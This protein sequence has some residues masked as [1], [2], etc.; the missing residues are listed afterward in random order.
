[1]AEGQEQ[2]EAAWEE[3]TWRAREAEGARLVSSAPRDVRDIWVPVQDFIDGLNEF[4]RDPSGYMDMGR[5]MQT[6]QKKQQCDDFAMIMA[7]W[8][9][10]VLDDLQTR[11]EWALNLAQDGCVSGEAVDSFGDSCDWYISMP[12]SCGNYDHEFFT[13]ALECCACGGGSTAE[14]ECADT[15]NGLGDR[16]GD[17]C[18]WYAADNQ[19]WCGQYDT[20]DFVANEMCCAC[21]GGSSGPLSVPEWNIDLDYAQADVYAA[22]LEEAYEAHHA[23]M[24]DVLTRWK[25]AR[26]EVD[27]YYWNEELLPVLAEGERLDER[28]MR[29][30][31]T[32]IADGTEIK[33]RPL[34]EVFPDVE[35]W[36]LDNY[37]P[38][39]RTVIE[40]FRME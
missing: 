12:D 28:T 14:P 11:D 13:A 40:T 39:G 33:G 4:G 17:G 10:K 2:L 6:A 25:Q 20:L 38:E 31:V 30:L 8:K 21:G 19:A 36:M 22:E 37:N 29:T 18:E 1:M 27:Q 7:E 34:V 3:A 23:R 35:E 32:W 9:Q 24:V 5:E 15:S 16:A 26:D